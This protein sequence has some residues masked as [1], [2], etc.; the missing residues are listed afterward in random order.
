[1]DKLRMTRRKAV[2]GLAGVGAVAVGA[3]CA[4]ETEQKADP[5]DLDLND[6][7][8]LAYARQKVVGSVAE[9][10]IHSFLRFHFYGQIPGEKAVPL[11]SMNN[12]IIDE[13]VPQE[14]PAEYQLRHWEVGYYCEF[15]TDN[16]LE[17]WLNPITNEEIEVW[18]FILG[19]IERLYTPETI[20]APGLAPLPRTSH[21]MGPRF[22][23]A[24]EAITQRP[25]IF[26]PDEWPKRSPG[27]MSNW[28]SMQT[29]SSLWEDVVN[30]E[31][32]SAPSNIHLQNFVSWSS[33]MQMGGRPG[34]T[35][36]RAYGAEIE[37]FEALPS[38]VYDGFKKYTPEIFET[39][40]WDQTRFDEFDYF[41]LM[42]ERR[43][44]GEV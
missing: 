7:I 19:P 23:V 6:P 36:A 3:G 29:L 15:D 10:E 8:D 32:T 5:L 21:I 18:H 20:Y 27:E 43:A 2:A 22:Y 39:A 26:K 4:S 12:Y 38:H 40:T 28:I 35:M 25:N 9:E 11:L 14:E 42:K 34:G 16:P 31:L 44:K 1:M 13:W 33:W 30:P 17:T 41:N 24:T 37:G